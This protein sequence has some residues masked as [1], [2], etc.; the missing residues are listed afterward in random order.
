[1]SLTRAQLLSGN[2]NQ[3]FV[4]PGQV[5]AITA[6]P[7]VSISPTGEIT[8]DTTDLSGF[9]KT[10]SEFAYNNYVW[11]PFDGT[12]GQ[13]LQTDG[14]G[15]LIWAPA[16]STNSPV[17]VG[18]LQPVNPQEGDLWFDCNVGYLKVYQNCVQPNGWSLTDYGLPVIAIDVSS[19][20][21]FT[22]GNG[23]S[24]NPY[25]LPDNTVP[26]GGSKRLATITVTGL[27]PNQFVPIQD[28]NGVTNSGRYDFST[29]FA[30][31]NGTLIFDIDFLDLPNSQVG[32]AYQAF[33][34]IG[35][36]TGA[37]ILSN[38][39]ITNSL[40]LTPGVILGTPQVSVPVNFIPGEASGGTP[41]YSYSYQWYADGVLIPGAT[42]VSYAPTAGQ[43][44][45]ILAV[46]TTAVDAL[47][48]RATAVATAST[49]VEFRPFPPSIWNGLP[50]D[51][52]EY[53]PG[54]Q[55]GTYFGV[56]S[57]I[58]A[59][60]CV[61]ASVNG[62]PYL[63]GSQPIANGDLLAIKW[64]SSIVCGGAA[65][66]T[67]ITGF[68]TDGNFYNAYSLTINRV[69]VPPI[70]DIFVDN[71]PLETSVASP[72]D[73]VISGLNS[74]AYV[75]FVATS[76]GTS[77]AASTDGKNFR[78]LDESG[79]AFPIDNGELLYISQGVGNLLSTD[80]VAT[81]R[82]GDGTN[83]AGTYD[84]FNFTAT[85]TNSS[86]FPNTVF[87][88]RNG[89]NASPPETE[90]ESESLYGTVYATWADGPCELTSTGG[91]WFNINGGTYDAGPQFIE[92]GDYI[93]L[94]WAPATIAGAADNSTLTGTLTNGVYTNVVAMVVDRAPVGLIFPDLTGQ[95]LSGPA[96]SAP[97]TPNGYNV[98]VTI[99]LTGGGNALTNPQ[100][101]TDGAAFAATPLTVNPGA[102][103]Y[104]RGTTGGA[105]GTTYSAA[106]TMGSS[107]PASDLWSVT[108]ALGAAGIVTPI[109]V[110]PENEA[111]NIDPATE[112]P[113]GVTITAT[114]Y[115]A[116]NA[117]G[118]QTSSTWEVYEGG[119]P[120][121]SSNFITGVTNTAA[122]GGFVQKP[123]AGGTY[124]ATLGG[125]NAIVST[126]N[127]VDWSFAYSY[128]STGTSI[129]V[130][131]DQGIRYTNTYKVENE[132]S[133]YFPTEVTGIAVARNANRSVH[134]V[135]QRSNEDSYEYDY[136]KYDD[137]EDD[138]DSAV[139][140]SG[141]EYKYEYKYGYKK[142]K[143]STQ[144]RVVA[145]IREADLHD[146]PYK[147][148]SL[149]A[150]YEGSNVRGTCAAFKDI[151]IVQFSKTAGASARTYYYDASNSSSKWI[152]FDTSIFPE[153]NLFFTMKDVCIASYNYGN[154]QVGIKR[155][156]DGITWTTVANPTGQT[157]TGLVSVAEG[158]GAY[159]GS[160]ESGLFVRSTNQGQSWSFYTPAGLPGPC[161]F[162]T[163]NAGIVAKPVDDT[164]TSVYISQD[165]G[166]TFT[167][168]VPTSYVGI[169]LGTGN[170]ILVGSPATRW[171]LLQD[172]VGNVIL[173]IVDADKDGFAIGD[174]VVS[175]PAGAGPVNIL[176]ITPTTV[177]VRQSTGWL[178]NGTQRL[179]LDPASYNALPGSPFTVNAAPFTQ[180]FVPGSSFNI[181][182]KYYTRVQYATTNPTAATSQFSAW[183][184]FTTGLSFDLK[185]GT[186]IWGGYYG[187][188]INDGGTIY[189]LIVAPVSEGGL[190][191]Q[192]DST[193][194]WATSSSANLG[195]S[196]LTDGRVATSFYSSSGASYPAINWCTNVSNGP[197]A[198][199]YDTLNATG[200][201]IGG[202]NDW[203]IPAYYELE[204]F[205]RAF[206]PTEKSNDLS[207]GKNPYALP[208]ETPTYSKYF[209]RETEVDDFEQGDEE[210]FSTAYPTWTA[211]QSITY[212]DRQ[213]QQSFSNGAQR[214]AYP[215]NY[216]YVRAIRRQL[217]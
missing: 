113:A 138:D 39:T 29:V 148:P 88:P 215:T 143:Y 194:Q 126:E 86:Q 131:K 109:I 62:G 41:P 71:C 101:S 124:Q 163:V 190:E 202:Y 171:W 85:T 185:V 184:K 34:K 5:Q 166:L 2:S 115:Q 21:V 11:P 197:N 7:G 178:G 179:A 46:E 142:K 139:L 117:A 9:V 68:L 121:L 89:P 155:S 217:A 207:S 32:T 110:T 127:R 132:D 118:A 199:I 37:Y 164:V 54:G 43:E 182:E 187:G 87:A 204:I 79:T 103:I 135:S 122:A 44:G 40:S 70:D 94:I 106:V 169:V 216:N 78:L 49:E 177:T 36:Y 158:S 105:T 42:G 180:V 173:N 8:V 25:T 35:A 188:Q 92:D 30:D 195:T 123:V 161:V 206:K 65:S 186:P 20:P 191:G 51:G 27:A 31:A 55:S 203:Y 99:T 130:S 14:N 165:G 211:S 201:G 196:S 61:I 60:G 174:S 100:V 170:N 16:T 73:N 176:D 75:N 152:A 1:M 17:T 97:V 136:D 160:T 58:T 69:P 107:P 150:P 48:S 120:L 47:F 200:T 213:F 74:T 80:Y 146:E 119:Y 72:I 95:P 210:A 102:N 147:A 66:G 28:L 23:A 168:Q 15:N 57:T 144:Y 33:I 175:D 167:L 212:T 129:Y 26:S 81:I 151:L 114:A 189:N 59:G 53:N 208:D 198:G 22:G 56:S 77:I 125:G 64:D 205:Y 154:N 140:G 13:F 193:L 108:T 45:T 172:I 10:N 134:V 137:D 183:S 153:A 91:L 18:F 104:L 128:R 156:L 112:S 192:S 84:E 214:V 116:L 90:I 157:F 159:V 63:T 145:Y 3:G 149:K 12:I 6:G 24:S 181:G 38:V 162:S 83:I 52:M 50:P 82:V 67:T 96:T 111:L 133:T 19:A 76:T 93:T 209:P 141:K 4:L 98:P